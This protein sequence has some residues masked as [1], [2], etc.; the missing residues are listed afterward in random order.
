MLCRS[1]FLYGGLPLYYV[2]ETMLLMSSRSVLQSE[3][4]LL[5]GLACWCLGVVKDSILFV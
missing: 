3:L 4:T 2:R 5:S 1:N